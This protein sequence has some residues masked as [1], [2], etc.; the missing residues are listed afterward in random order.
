MWWL[1][2]GLAWGGACPT[3]VAAEPLEAPAER[4]P[5]EGTR[6]SLV[7]ATADAAEQAVP[8]ALVVL[9]GP[10]GQVLGGRSD[11]QGRLRLYDLPEGDWTLRADG[12]TVQG[13]RVTSGRPMHVPIEVA[14]SLSARRPVDV[15]LAGDPPWVRY[16]RSGCLGPCLAFDVTVTHGGEVHWS[17]EG[18]EGRVRLSERELAK[19]RELLVCTRAMPV[20]RHRQK[21]DHAWIQL[22]VTESAE[23]AWTWDWYTGDDRASYGDLER[24]TRK[25]ERALGVVLRAR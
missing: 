12:R 18:Q 23:S 21:T 11:D 2:L 22:D 5:T 25:L 8:D 14:P 7:V 9:E 17:G 3:D 1:V 4:A 19:L 15:P 24:F 20:F 13:V 6:V 16:R 10:E